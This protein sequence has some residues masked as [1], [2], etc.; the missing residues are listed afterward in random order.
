MKIHF[1]NSKNACMNSI[2]IIS[3]LWFSADGGRVSIV[4]ACS[5]NFF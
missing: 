1:D 2:K 4:I 3:N 5:K